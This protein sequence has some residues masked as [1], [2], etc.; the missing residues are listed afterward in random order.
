MLYTQSFPFHAARR[1]LRTR[2]HRTIYVISTLHWNPQL[3]CCRWYS[4]DT[5]NSADSLPRDAHVVIAGG[6]IVGSSVAYHLAKA[7]WKDIVL[8]DQGRL[9][10]LLFEVHVISDVHMSSV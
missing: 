2:H 10:N 9:V 4:A 8:L 3:S 1:M 7:G 5:P 6:G